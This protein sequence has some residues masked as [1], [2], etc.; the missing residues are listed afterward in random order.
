MADEQVVDLDDSFENQNWLRLVAKAGK[1]RKE[2]LQAVKDGEAPNHTPRSIF[3]HDARKGETEDRTGILYEMLTGQLPFD[4]ETPIGV[5]MQH[6]HSEPPSP[7][8]YNPELPAR[9]VGVVM[10]ALEKDPERRYRDAGEFASALAAQAAPDLG[11][12]TVVTDVVNRHDVWVRAKTRG[13]LRLLSEA[14][15]EGLVT[16]IFGVE[17]L[18][19]DGTAQTRT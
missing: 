8:E 5:A 3:L 14:L 16:R 4:A 11:Q 2:A 10:R 1:T 13:E 19:G 17:N 9:A 7:C 6:L 18:Y 15:H 12:T